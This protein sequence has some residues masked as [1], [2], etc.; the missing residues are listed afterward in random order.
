MALLSTTQFFVL[1]LTRKST[2][3]ATKVFQKVFRINFESIE[4]N[5][6]DEN[7]RNVILFLLK[8]SYHC[9]HILAY[10]CAF[11]KTKLLQRLNSVETIISN[12][13]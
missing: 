10:L 6:T 13:R 2:V 4:A 1:C 11:I 8:K 7:E 12:R 3:I 9:I 5:V